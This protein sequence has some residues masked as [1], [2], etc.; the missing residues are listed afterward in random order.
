MIIKSIK[1]KKLT[2]NEINTIIT[3][4]LRLEATEHFKK[5]GLK[6]DDITEILIVDYMRTKLKL[7]IKN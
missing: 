7:Y 5:L 3:P 6:D 1:P 2:L 4:K